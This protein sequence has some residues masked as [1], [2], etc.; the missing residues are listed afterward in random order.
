MVGLIMA[1]PL[2]PEGAPPAPYEPL[3]EQD[4]LAVCRA[5]HTCATISA[6]VRQAFGDDRRAP[7]IHAA[8]R[9]DPIGFGAHVERARETY[10]NAIRGEIFRRG[11]TGI[12]RALVHQGVP[13]GFT[14]KE[15]S[16]E[17][18]KVAAR[19][20][21]PEYLDKKQ[22]SDIH[23]HGEI[24]IQEQSAGIWSIT[25]AEALSLPDDLKHKLADVLKYLIRHRRELAREENAVGDQIEQSALTDQGTVTD[26]EFAEVSS[27]DPYDLAEVE[28]MK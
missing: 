7:A 18:L 6:A 1:R 15:Y 12:D 3:T 25:D 23:V 5:L 20:A 22:A 11:V 21:L 24:A 8:V 26:A 19:L 17:M 9:N 13:T 27:A 2:K 10:R 4:K 28:K 16:D 14:V